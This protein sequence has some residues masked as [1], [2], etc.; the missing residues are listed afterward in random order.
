MAGL[1][2][3]LKKDME[4]NVNVT[5]PPRGTSMDWFSGFGPPTYPPSRH[6]LFMTV[7]FG[8]SFPSRLRGSGGF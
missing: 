3:R 1:W 6:E 7:A 2:N 4:S 8:F 5:I